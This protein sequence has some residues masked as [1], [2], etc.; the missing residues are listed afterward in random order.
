MPRILKPVFA[1]AAASLL[2]ACGSSSDGLANA[3][4]DALDE[5]ACSTIGQNRF[6]YEVMQDIYFWNQFLPV[7][8]PDT[9]NSPEELLEAIREYSQ[10]E[11]RFGRVPSTQ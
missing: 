4:G 3:L 6:V 5:S 9:F 8:N 11:R 7:V 2:G 1:L 10:R